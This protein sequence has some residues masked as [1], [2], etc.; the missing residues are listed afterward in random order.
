[1]HNVNC[2]LSWFPLV[3][4]SLDYTRHLDAPLKVQPMFVSSKYRITELHYTYGCATLI[5]V[6]VGYLYLE[7]PSFTLQLWVRHLK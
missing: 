3:A 1:M 4:E 7:N 2:S 6:Y 5:A